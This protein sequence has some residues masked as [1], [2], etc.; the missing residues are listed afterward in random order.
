MKEIGAQ[1]FKNVL[2]GRIFKKIVK[3][4]MHGNFIGSV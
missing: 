3:F 1:H 2:M 4:R